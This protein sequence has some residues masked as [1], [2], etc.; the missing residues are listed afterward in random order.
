MQDFRGFCFLDVVVIVNRVPLGSRSYDYTAT[1]FGLANE[2]LSKVWTYLANRTIISISERGETKDILCQ[3]PIYLN[4]YS[5]RI[6]EK[7]IAVGFLLSTFNR[8]RL[9]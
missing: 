9:L 8:W 7:K 2:L 3:G 1:M 6:L 5:E 4:F